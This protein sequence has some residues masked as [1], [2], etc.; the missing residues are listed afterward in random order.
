MYFI[1]IIENKAKSRYIGF[2]SNIK[3]R[4]TDHNSGKGT[5]TTKRSGKWKLI[6]LEG[7]LDKKDALGREQFLKSGF[8]NRFIKKQLNNYFER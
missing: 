5:Q 7:Y 3:K 4:I 2:T 1:Y 8:G 6:Y